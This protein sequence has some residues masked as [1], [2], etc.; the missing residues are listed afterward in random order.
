MC[1]VETSAK[2]VRLR[3]SVRLRQTQTSRTCD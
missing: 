1:D 3:Q 2:P